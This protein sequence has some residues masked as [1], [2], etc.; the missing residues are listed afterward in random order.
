MIAWWADDNARLKT[1]K[2]QINALLLRSTWLENVEWS[3]DNSLRICVSFDV[4][5]DHGSFSLIL[6]YHNTFPCSPPSVAPMDKGRLSS[7][8]YEN[9]DL[10][11]EIRPDNWRQEFTG[12]DMIE[13]AYS[14]LQFEAPDGDGSI[15]IAPSAHNVPDSITH[16][17][18]HSRFYVTPEVNQALLFNA[19]N[20]AKARIFVQ[21]SGLEFAV[22]HLESLELKDFHW[23]NRS[24]PSALEAE[25]HTRKGI[26]IRTEKSESGLY[27]VQTVS[28]LI[29]TTN[30]DPGF[31][32]ELS[33]VLIV[34]SDEKFILYVKLPDS[35]Q[36]YRYQ[37]IF[38]PVESQKRSGEEFNELES[39]KVGIVGLGS[40][41]SK[42]AITMARAGLKKFEL[43]DG[44]ILHPGNL[45][46]HDADWRDI[47]VHKVDIA[48]RRLKLISPDVYVS[49]RKTFI[50][51][52]VS[53]T[54]AGNVNAA[55][56]SCDI[57]IDATANPHAFNHLAG[58]SIKAKNSLFWAG[59]YAGGIGGF[60][61]RSRYS[62][63]PEPFSV[64]EALNQYYSTI[65]TPPPI[66][67]EDGYDGRE[68]NAVLTASDADV[69]IISAHLAN[70]AI[71]TALKREP[72]QFEHQIY[73]IGLKRAW[74]FDA[75]FDV[76]PVMVTTSAREEQSTP[77]TA[78]E[79]QQFIN[80]LI[81]KKLNEIKDSSQD[82]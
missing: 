50:G 60:I 40:L 10:C 11:L 61:A 64:R 72:S 23:V 57:I 2:D 28:D 74:I 3:F 56:V 24:I 26:V 49:T 1:E 4:T 82:S 71:D 31:S 45:E 46:R 8:Q 17:F 13:S 75:A 48:S 65:D 39:V 42:V 41:G 38:S 12:A 81:A 33:F 51:A 35:D 73:I 18:V 76:R 70:L 36:L 15:T 53:S 55:L 29:S 67:D 78:P 68:E 32:K 30:F 27:A 14:L 80:T 77:E 22:A 21:W 25:A 59:I 52:Q 37:S 5:L 19:P 69:G 63:D 54:E 43:V 16:R 6:T 20:M 9:G 62:S 66:H 47:G 79:Q 58:L 44:D 7:H 34:T